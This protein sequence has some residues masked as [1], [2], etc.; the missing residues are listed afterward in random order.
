MSL[1]QDLEMPR[2]GD[3]LFLGFHTCPERCLSEEGRLMLDAV[4]ELWFGRAVVR[5][6]QGWS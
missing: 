1:D 4:R 3:S 5:G 2:C 6:V